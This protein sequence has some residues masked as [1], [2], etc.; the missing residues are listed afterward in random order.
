MC[1]DPLTC[2]RWPFSVECKHQKI[3]TPGAIENFVHGRKSTIDKFWKQCCTA[4]EKDGVWPLLVFRG[5]KM[6]FRVAYRSL[7]TGGVMVR[8]LESFLMY[9][10]LGFAVAFESRSA[11]TGGIL[12]Q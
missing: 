11:P 8:L 4:A 3:V 7:S 5:D 2:K 12:A 6:P 10:P 9:D 1:Y